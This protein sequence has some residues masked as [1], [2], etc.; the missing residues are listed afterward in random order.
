MSK[1]IWTVQL[2]GCVTINGLVKYKIKF[3]PTNT[4]YFAIIIVGKLQAS[5][6]SRYK[7]QQFSF[8]Y[9][10]EVVV[11]AGICEYEEPRPGQTSLTGLAGNGDAGM[12]IAVTPSNYRASAAA[13]SPRSRG[14]GE[15]I[16]WAFTEAAPNQPV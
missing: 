13:S 4:C 10:K 8:N 11:E 16:I 6:L 2:L 15:V 7:I 3:Y 14:S 9:P 5:I 1:E 12:M